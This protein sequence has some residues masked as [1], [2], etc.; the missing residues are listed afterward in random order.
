MSSPGRIIDPVPY[1]YDAR[2]EREL[3]GWA[4]RRAE[5]LGWEAVSEAW[6]G[7]RDRA[8]L[9]LKRHPNIVLVE[10]KLAL[11]TL[12]ALRA[13]VNQVVRYE[14]RIEEYW[15][16]WTVSPVVLAGDL[17]PLPGPWEDPFLIRRPPPR[18]PIYVL[19]DLHF[20]S[21]IGGFPAHPEICRF[22]NLRWRGWLEVAA[23][24]F[25][26]CALMEPPAN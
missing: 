12:D 21:F 25:P 2:S 8:D 14:R 11:R 6:V 24:R 17:W 20:E 26:R 9:I 4:H 23:C 22:D 7:Q 18:Q 5:D 13:A 1:R 16:A 19:H 10:C 15:P 3:H